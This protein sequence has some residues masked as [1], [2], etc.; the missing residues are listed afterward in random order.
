M[1]EKPVNFFYCSTQAVD[2][3]LHNN[4]ANSGSFAKLSVPVYNYNSL[5]QDRL[6][7][8]A[9]DSQPVDRLDF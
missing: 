3:S 8:T 9:Q 6:Q 4:F 2:F 1:R 7:S 5:F